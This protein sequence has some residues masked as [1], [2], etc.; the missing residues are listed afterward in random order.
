[1][2][3]VLQMKTADTAHMGISASDTRPFS[4]FLGTRLCMYVH[5]YVLSNLYYDCYISSKTNIIAVCLR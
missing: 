1:M 5:V 4:G 3:P 2:I